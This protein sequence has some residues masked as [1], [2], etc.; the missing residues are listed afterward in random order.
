MALDI[1]CP[2]CGHLNNIP[3]GDAGRDVICA[4]CQTTLA[5]SAVPHSVELPAPT[6]WPIVLSLGIALLTIGVA[7]NLVLS[8]V[9]AV[10]FVFGLAGWIVQM[11]AGR[12][13]RT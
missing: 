3:D 7:T 12:G 1:V 13:S 9:G 5:A 10:V 2:S 11:T 4:Q 6:V 8:V